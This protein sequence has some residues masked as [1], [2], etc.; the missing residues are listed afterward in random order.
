LFL[1]DVFIIRLVFSHRCKRAKCL[2]S[3]TAD[4]VVNYNKLINCANSNNN[5]DIVLI[6]AVV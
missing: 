1:L 5:N 2:R 4:D 6:V 3:T